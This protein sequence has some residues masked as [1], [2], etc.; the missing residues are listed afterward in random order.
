MDALYQD[1]FGWDEPD[2]ADLE[3]DTNGDFDDLNERFGKGSKLR[4]EQ[5]RYKEKICT[6][7]R[8]RLKGH[9]C[10]SGPGVDDNSTTIKKSSLERAAVAATSQSHMQPAQPDT[11]TVNPELRTDNIQAGDQCPFWEGWTSVETRP[12]QSWMQQTRSSFGVCESR[13]WEEYVSEETLCEAEMRTNVSFESLEPSRST[14]WRSHASRRRTRT[15]WR[16][17]S[18]SWS[19]TTRSKQRAGRGPSP[20]PSPYERDFIQAVYDRPYARGTG[21]VLGLAAPPVADLRDVAKWASF[22]Y[23]R[24]VLRCVGIFGFAEIALKG[25]SKKLDPWLVFRWLLF[26]EWPRMG[27]LA[28]SDWLRSSTTGLFK[29][30]RMPWA[31]DRA[32]ECEVD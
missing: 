25:T 31:T 10:L 14:A 7:C 3:G 4:C 1:T 30:L 2:T 18:P 28:M 5:C 13:S 9:G 16:E 21:H 12:R 19:R 17:R 29:A 24:A 32:G 11:S 15:R 26:W 22:D 6:P 8:Q 23:K 20:K 27:V